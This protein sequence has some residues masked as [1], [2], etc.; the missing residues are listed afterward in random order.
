MNAIRLKIAAAAT[1]LALFVAA[2]ATGAG[3]SSA[4]GSTILTNAVTE[5]TQVAVVVNGGHVEYLRLVGYGD[6]S[7]AVHPGRNTA[8]VRWSGPVRRI[9]FQIRYSTSPDNSRDIL[10]VRADATRDAALRRAG[11]RTYTFTIPV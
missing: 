6:I 5:T 10:V 8:T 11:S 2:P 9:D 1:V 4:R 3:G 7:Y